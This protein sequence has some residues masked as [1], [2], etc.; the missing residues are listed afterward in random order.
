MVTY[1]HLGWNAEKNCN[2]PCLLFLAQ[3]H[4]ISWPFF[5]ASS[6]VN[7]IAPIL[8][9]SLHYGSSAILL[10]VSVKIVATTTRGSAFCF[11]QFWENTLH[12]FVTPYSSPLYAGDTNLWPSSRT[13]WRAYTV[14]NVFDPFFML[15]SSWHRTDT[16]TWAATLYTK[17]YSS[18]I[19]YVGRWQWPSCVD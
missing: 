2:K 14:R 7:W 6:C 9:D 17:S 16:F 8:V 12:E 18:L 11:S 19:L 15:F 3:T 10:P 4:S 5:I 1:P 13:L